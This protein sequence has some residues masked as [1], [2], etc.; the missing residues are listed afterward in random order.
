MSN[1]WHNETFSI[2]S[3]TNFT[4]NMSFTIPSKSN[5][6][7]SLSMSAPGCAASLIMF[8]PW[9]LSNVT[10][11]TSN[12]ITVTTG[13]LAVSTQQCTVAGTTPLCI[14]TTGLAC[15]DLS[16]LFSLQS[17]CSQLVL[18]MGITNQGPLVFLPTAHPEPRTVMYVAV[19][20]IG[21]VMIIIVL[22]LLFT[23]YHKP[24]EYQ[25]IN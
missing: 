10:N 2:I 19:A 7:Y 13:T 18:S 12:N 21:F 8:G 3:S 22:V 15:H 23:V 4:I 16:V 17:N 9:S 25:S 14:N 24:N 20:V 1:T 11:S 6:S 5:F